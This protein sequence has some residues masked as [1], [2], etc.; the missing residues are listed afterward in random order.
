MAGGTEFGNCVRSGCHT[1]IGHRGQT[2]IWEMYFESCSRSA[3]SS[4]IYFHH[5]VDRR[6]ESD[7]N[8]L[9]GI[10]YTAKQSM[11]CLGF[12][13]SAGVPVQV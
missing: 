1:G 4:L 9:T 8:T 7:E 5:A 6:Q 3:G 11:V 13:E 2:T 12:G 10:V